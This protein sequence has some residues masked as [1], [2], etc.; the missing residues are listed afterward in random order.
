LFGIDLND[1]AVEIAR[2]SLWIKT[3]EK[4]KQLTALD[5]NVKR[6]NSVVSS[7][8]PIDKWHEW[9]PAVFD[10]GGFDVVIGNPPYVRH[11]HFKDD[12]QFLKQ[13]FHAYDASADLYVYFYEIGLSLL[14]P[15][16]RLGYIVTNKWMKAGYGRPLRE[17]FDK[18]AWVESVIDFGHAKAIFP[19][20]D[21]FP[22]ILTARRPDGTKRPTDV[23]VCDL[24]SKAVD[25]DNLPLVVSQHEITIP[26]K[27][28]VPDRWVLGTELELDLLNTLLAKG[29]TVDPI[30]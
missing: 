23:R 17:V 5:E 9:F 8:S 28:L 19:D 3:A 2:L 15:G 16:G 29:T 13:H 20:A 1:E 11:D 25:F 21:V 10:K 14:K 24:V 18:S 26:S 30:V 22:C 6:G 4:G 12:K 7:P 27:R